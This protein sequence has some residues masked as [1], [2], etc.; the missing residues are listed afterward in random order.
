MKLLKKFTAVV[1][2][3]AMLSVGNIGILQPCIVSGVDASGNM[4]INATAT[5]QI[6]VSGTNSLGDLISEEINGAA[7]ET[8]EALAN[9]T[10][11]IY[12]LNMQGN[13]ANV[14]CYGKTGATLF[15]GIYDE[16]GLQLLASGTHKIVTTDDEVENIE[17]T[18]AIKGE[19]P[20]YFLV[21]AFMLDKKQ[22][23]L[24]EV[25][26]CENYTESITK[27]RESVITDYDPELVVNLDEKE[28]TNFLVLE[29]KTKKIEYNGTSNILESADDEK[30]IYVFKNAD[31]TITSLGAGDIFYYD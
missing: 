8:A 18:V 4:E 26:V 10:Y 16:K 29:E 25:Y 17:A 12:D 14:V 9:D 31:E 19:I 15:V 6:D 27:V 7:D 13:N 24:C 5:D 11:G 21:K 3:V 28:D 20:E 1:T 2:A 22:I 30:L 23:P